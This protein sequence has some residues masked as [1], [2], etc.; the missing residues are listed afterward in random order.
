ML[1]N[2]QNRRFSRKWKSPV[3]GFWTSRSI[4]CLE[5]FVRFTPGLS[6]VAHHGYAFGK[7]MVSGVAIAMY[8]SLEITEEG[9][10][11]FSPSCQEV[12]IDN[13]RVLLILF[14]AEDPHVTLLLGR[15]V[16]LMERLQRCFVR[17]ANICCL[18]TLFQQR[19]ERAR[20]HS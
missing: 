14:G 17:M 19:M 6:H 5:P 3:W 8:I 2:K 11:V 9:L 12:L 18:Y 20:S 1:P 13:G 7:V 4:A 16:R 15:T 10:R